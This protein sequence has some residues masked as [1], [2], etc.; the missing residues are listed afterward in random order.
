M[1]ISS[2]SGNYY[3]YYQN[4]ISQSYSTTNTTAST[5]GTEEMMPPPPPPPPQGGQGNDSSFSSSD[6]QELMDQFKMSSDYMRN[7]LNGSD[8][9]FSVEDFSSKEDV[10]A[11]IDALVETDLSSLSDEEISDTLASLQSTLSNAP[12]LPQVANELVNTDL[13]NLSISQQDDL[14]TDL[15]DEASALTTGS[16]GARRAGGPPPPPTGGQGGME[17]TADSKESTIAELMQDLLEKISANS[18]DYDTG[19]SDLLASLQE[20]MLSYLGQS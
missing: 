11:S 17:S 1:D 10:K 12:Y 15:Q 5:R 9:D 20:S 19:S 3:N 6:P 14:L 18:E 2:V 4:S 8:S 16:P 7:Q 13:D